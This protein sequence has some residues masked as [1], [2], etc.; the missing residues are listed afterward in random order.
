MKTVK[1]DKL[2]VLQRTFEHEGRC[3]FVLTLLC[4]FDFDKPRALLSE[5]DLWKLAADELA[6][7]SSV[8]DEGNVK[9][10][11]E[12]LVNGKCFP[13][14][15]EPTGVSF[16]RVKLGRVDKRL[17]VIG[18]RVWKMGVPTKP[19]PFTEMPV[20][21]LHAFGGEGFEQNPVGKGYRAIDI[22]GDE[23]HPLPN[24]E[25]P[26]RLIDSPSDRPQPVGL[27][28]YDFT[29]PQRFR[30]AGTYD[31]RWLET[32]YPGYA[33]DMDPT[34][35]NLG[36]EDQYL[37]GYFQGGERFL[38]ENMHPQ[39]P[40]IEG[41]VSDVVPRAFITHRRPNGEEHF[42]EIPMR[43]DTVR[44]IPHREVG[45]VSFRGVH[46]VCEDDA[47]DV[48]H[49]VAALEA[50]GHRRTV[51]HY[52]HALALRLDKE[53]GALMALKNDDLMPPDAEG[54]VPR[55]KK[56][57]VELWV[58][59]EDLLAQNM[60]RK[61]ENEFAKAK[62]E[63]E[64]A[65]LDPA[66]FHMEELPP[67]PERLDPDDVDAIAAWMEEEQAEAARAKQELE[68]RKTEMEEA[69]RAQFAA[70]GQDYD[71]A[72]AQA[73]Q[74]AA[75]PP[76]FKADAHVVQLQQLLAIAREGNAPMEEFERQL[77]DP[78]YLEQ[79]HD[80]EKRLVE[81]YKLSA[82]VQHPFAPFGREES[83]LFRAEIE[84][85]HHN[86]IGLEERDFSGAHLGGMSLAGMNLRGA[87]L[88]AVDL[89]GTNLERANLSGAVLA[90]ATIRDTKLAGADLSGANLGS[91]VIDGADL[92]G[93]NLAGVVLMRSKLSR[94]SL[95]GATLERVNFLET[96]FGEGLDLREL[97]GRRLHFLRLDLREAQLAGADL[98][99]STFLEVDLRGVDLTGIDLTRAS[100]LGC[101]LDDAIFRKA[102]LEGCQFVY[103]TTLER[104]DFS[105][106]HMAT[107]LL[108]GLRANGAKFDHA[109]L[110]KAD[111]SGARLSGASFY[112]TKAR[113]SLTIR[114]DFSGAH[115][116]SIDLLRAIMQKADLR[117]ADL[118]GANL[119][120][121]DLAKALVD[122]KTNV[123]DA[124][125]TRSRQIPRAD[126]GPQ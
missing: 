119:F 42:V 26:R 111:L 43:L 23:V 21:W 125:L 71:E 116:V 70:E 11:G 15:P 57:D 107:A 81:L 61:M 93:A 102:K 114:T 86:E 103:Q 88:E 65:G 84:V 66:D 118:K 49:L 72:V 13:P 9:V 78:K 16:V 38:V 37:A 96:Q 48:V 126:H 92:S 32:R 113:D 33:K 89:T 63:I 120:G 58:Q 74:D 77:D 4:G 46:E 22:D 45:M 28:A 56:T 54:F 39:K 75:G 27:G 35:F 14:G 17:A 91:A 83:D 51:D 100:F 52:Q 108:R 121:V 90:H 44:L 94:S 98:S 36:P 24:V 85:A 104:A 40:R 95:R 55:P 68:R 64:E 80:L 60:R 47:S 99:E 12:L 73:L 18:D 79:L 59:K 122:G 115:M 41:T 34:I 19:E 25:D 124:N 31:R 50:P 69:A 30:K 5:V 67:P 101:K 87:F 8:I 7:E 3:Q 29:W 97:V 76:T 109:C 62:A 20:D 82:H 6:S 2:S 106:A 117:G 10:R 105:G 123:D 53:K 110:D 1:P 112:Q